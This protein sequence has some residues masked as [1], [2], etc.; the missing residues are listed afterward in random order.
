MPE[1]KSAWKLK[2]QQQQLQDT[3]RG[4]GKPLAEQAQGT[5]TDNPTP[6][7]VGKPLR[8]IELPVAEEEHEYEVDF[9]IE[10]I[11]QD[12]VVEDQERM[13][14]IQEKVDKLRTG[15]HTKSIIEDV[16]KT[17]KSTR[18][19]EESSRTIPELGNVEPKPFNVK[20]A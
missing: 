10:G 17:G 14:K 2:Q 6:R 1:W 11:P 20:R 3:V 4:C 16:G 13:T 18:F 7:S 9:R 8:G 5:P 12:A 15:Y 19:S